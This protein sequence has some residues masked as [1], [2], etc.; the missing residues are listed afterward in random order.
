M[1]YSVKWVED[2]LGISR[3]ALRNYEH[4]GLMPMAM[5]KVRDYDEEDINY[6]WCIKLLNGIGFTVKEIKAMI[7]NPSTDFYGAITGKVEALEHKLAEDEQYLEFAK[8]I[9]MTGR[10]PTVSQL[11]VLKFEDFMN[12]AKEQWNFFREPNVALYLGLMDLPTYRKSQ[13]SDNIT[14]EQVGKLE[15]LLASFKESQHDCMITA[16]YKILGEM[17]ELDY[18]NS[19]VQTVVKLLYSLVSE[20]FPDEEARRKFDFARFAR[21]SVPFFVPGSDLYILNEQNYGADACRFIAE[22][23]ACFGG[24]DTV[25]ELL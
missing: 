5:G 2:N 25:D 18:R 16:Y 20:D 19:A 6:I 7:D 14:A 12:Y 9:K 22:A 1:G 8:T 3:K 24:F 11:G 17:R 4:Y 21:Y 13:P 10:I 15:E 23:I